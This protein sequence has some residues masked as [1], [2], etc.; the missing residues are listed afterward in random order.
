M[1]AYWAYY[2]RVPGILWARAG[3]TIKV[4][5]ILWWVVV[6]AYYGL[7]PPPD[8]EHNSGINA[9]SVWAFG[10]IPGWEHNPA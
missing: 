5:G 1:G 3:Y 10:I 4:K 2:R 8:A 9:P 7:G 6:R